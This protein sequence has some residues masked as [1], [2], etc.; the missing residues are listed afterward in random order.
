MKFLELKKDLA[1]IR[2]CYIISGNDRYLCYAALNQIKAA[3]NITLPQMNE[4]V[5]GSEA[6]AEDIANA[7]NVFP[8]VDSYRLVQVNEF[9]QKKSAGEQELIKVLKNPMAECVLVFFNLDSTEA[10]KPYMSYAATVDCNKLRP[11]E[12]KPILTAK[13]RKSGFEISDDALN[14]LVLFCNS[15]M[16]RI[17][18][19]LEKLVSY[20][21]GRNIEKKDVEELVIEDKEY[22]VFQLSEFI[23]RGEKDKALDLVYALTNGKSAFTLIAPLYNNFRRALYCAINRTKSDEELAE[24]LGVQPYAIKMTRNQV[25][26]YTPK[27]L[28]AIVD[29]LYNTDRNIKMGKIKEDVAIKTATLNIL[30]I[31]G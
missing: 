29:L 22:Q 4:V 26:Y 14:E 3:L 6:T 15:D 11:E 25:G 21:D 10:L 20:C 12:L 8:F 24:T 23:A 28:K 18:G 31:R 7:V 5:L 19:E 17:N 2:P 9:S 27:K 1:K 30:K 13:V 16:T